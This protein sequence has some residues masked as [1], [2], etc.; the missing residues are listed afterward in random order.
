MATYGRPW[1]QSLI[2]RMPIPGSGLKVWLKADSGVA[3]S[4]GNVT[5]WTD[6]ASGI[7]FTTAGVGPAPTLVANSLNGLPV[8]RF[9]NSGG[10]HQVC[11]LTST[12]VNPSSWAGFTI[13]YATRTAASGSIPAYACVFGWGQS[14]STWW[15]FACGSA[16]NT[17]D[18]Q[19]FGWAGASGNVVLGSFASAPTNSQL[20][21][22]AYQYD[23]TTW[24]LSGQ[25]SNTVSDTS[26]PTGNVTLLI[27]SNTYPQSQNTGDIAEILVYDHKLSASD[28]AT[29]HAYMQTRW[30]VS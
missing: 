7:V 19:G 27:G 5:T 15:N 13:I 25:R 21:Y 18:N 28:L 6:Q 4:S 29:V 26:F 17:T 9:N 11:Y 23:K 24:T 2:R 8:V 22:E 1:S 12:P 20:V 3:T 10:D 30:G 16:N 14:P